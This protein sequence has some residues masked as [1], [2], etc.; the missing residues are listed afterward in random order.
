MK[1]ISRW[2]LDQRPDGN[3]R[4]S[5][6]GFC[7]W[8][9]NTRTMETPKVLGIRAPADPPRARGRKRK[10]LGQAGQGMLTSPSV[11]ETPSTPCRFN[12]SGRQ[13]QRADTDGQEPGHPG[14]NGH[15]L[16]GCPCPSGFGSLGQLS[17][18]VRVCPCPGSNINRLAPP[19]R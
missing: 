8:C 2:F 18:F 15:P 5:P 11:L 4:P 7:H 10:T 9:S 12:H 17:A 1:L 16:I 19:A 3:Q 14:T 6:L 13:A